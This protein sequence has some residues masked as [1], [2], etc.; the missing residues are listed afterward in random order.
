MTPAEHLTRAEA[1]R[2]AGDDQ[3][4]RTHALLAIAGA[5]VA[6]MPKE[7]PPD[8]PMTELGCTAGTVGRCIAESVGL[9]D[10]HPPARYIHDCGL[11]HDHPG[12]HEC[13]CGHRWI[14]VDE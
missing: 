12:G 9:C 3:A 2:A 1:E 11:D 4:A 8:D 13:A 7:T 10:L 5:L 6:Q 14:E